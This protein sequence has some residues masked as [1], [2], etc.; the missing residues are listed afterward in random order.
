MSAM[1]RRAPILSLR[2]NSGLPFHFLLKYSILIIR[3][4]DQHH[5]ILGWVCVHLQALCDNR[6]KETIRE[7]RLSEFLR[8]IVSLTYYSV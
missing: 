3:Y 2:K 7:R 4:I 8:I 1:E 5:H 6:Q